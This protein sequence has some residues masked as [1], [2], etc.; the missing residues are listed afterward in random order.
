MD[1]AACVRSSDNMLPVSEFSKRN[2][3]PAWLMWPL[4][5]VQVY[6]G[7]GGA[8]PGTQFQRTY[9][10]HESDKNRVKMYKSV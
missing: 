7:K 4:V 10:N 2:P 6:L 3:A 5:R 9:K 1:G 8:A